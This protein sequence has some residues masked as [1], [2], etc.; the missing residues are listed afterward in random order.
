MSFDISPL[1]D[2]WDYQPGQLVV[3]K[4]LGKDGEEFPDHKLAGLIIPLVQQWRN[5][6][7]HGGN[8]NCAPRQ[9]NAGMIGFRLD[10]ALIR[11]PWSRR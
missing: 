7:A 5:I 3:R 8:M 2:Q 4:F 6:E 10:P 9:V 11:L 1:L